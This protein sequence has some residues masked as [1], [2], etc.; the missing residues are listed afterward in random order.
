M[1]G[2]INLVFRPGF[3]NFEYDFCTIIFLGVGQEQN[4]D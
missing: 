1:I 3:V 2:T 4:Y